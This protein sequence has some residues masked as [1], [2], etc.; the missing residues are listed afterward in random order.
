MGGS[1]PHLPGPRGPPGVVGMP[2][3]RPP[4]GWR[5]PPPGMPAFF[6][7]ALRTNC[8]FN[9][10]KAFHS[11]V[12]KTAHLVVCCVLGRRSLMGGLL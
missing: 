4:M 1:G 3:G 5:P 12:A 11:L 2:G 9:V 8:S 10:E 6:P 7:G